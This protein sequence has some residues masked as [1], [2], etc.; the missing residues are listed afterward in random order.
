MSR[1]APY[2]WVA[3]LGTALALSWW[4]LD[5]LGRHYGM[6]SILAGMV[7][8]TF[9]GGALVAADLALRRAAKGHPTAAVKLL[10]IGT[11]GLSAW[12][13][14]Q[15][16]QLLG[17]PVAI[18]VLFAAPPVIAGWLFELQ[19][20]GV[21]Q[22]RLE[23]RRGTA[24]SIPRLGLLVWLFHPWAALRRTSQIAGSRLRSIPISVADWKAADGVTAEA[25]A[26]PLPPCEPMAELRSAGP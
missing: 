14:Y 6:P 15:H 8:A 4:S 24:S 9:D 5:S 1:L 7:S 18:R 10:M 20:G 26:V 12:L 25:M 13:N 16:G 2:A 17:Y 11:V 23:E 3:V 22:D 21:H 19:L